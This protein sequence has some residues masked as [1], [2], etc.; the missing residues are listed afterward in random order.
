M[1]KLIFI[2]SLLAFLAVNASAAESIPLP[3]T[4]DNSIVLVDGEWNQNAGQQG[5]IRI[6]GNQHIV[7]MAFDTSSISGKR[8]T[9]ATLVCA[10]G[11]QT[12]S[13][14]TL[15]TIAAPWDENRSTGLTAGVD[16]VEGWGYAG[17]R[18]PA[19]CGGNSFTLA[20]E[21]NS[22]IHD[23]YYHWDVPPDMVHAMAI[24]VAH[25]LAIHEHD[26]DYG[27]NPAIFSRE[28]SGKK[29]RLIVEFDDQ[30]D[31][32]PGPP[33][34]LQLSHSD[35]TSARLLLTA[36][37]SGF[38]YEVL[39][40]GRPLGRHNI[41]L[42]SG[43]SS[44]II[45]L[46]DLPAFI[47]G[48]EPHEIRVVTLNRTG[49]RSEAAVIRGSVFKSSPLDKP[50]VVI[51]PPHRSP[52]DNLSVI[53]IT[54]KY[55]A[56]GQ[57]VGELP[58][59]YRTH[60]VLFDGQ[61]VRLVAAAGEVTGFQLL[62]R[63][64]R[65]VTVKVVLD[66]DGRGSKT[67]IDLLQAVYVPS[68]GRMIPDPLLPL[69]DRIQLSP[70]RDQ[71]VVADLFLPFDASPGLR[72][73]TIT[74]SDGRVIPLEIEV[75]PFALPRQATFFCEMN[76]YGLP[77]HVNDYYAHQ[78]VAYD[79][80]VHAN[81]L[82]YSHNTAAP[83][84]RKS[85]LDMRLR[86][87]RRMDNQRY[88][89]IPPEATAAF[90]DDF[91]EAFG[92][93]IDGS[94]FKDGHRGPVPAPGFYLTFHES[95]P[96]NCRAFFNGNPDAFQAFSEKPEYARTYVNI[97]QDF[98]RLAKSKGWT[99]TG[100]QVYFNNKGSLGESSKAPW[101][102][103]EP[104]SFW[105]YRALKFYGELT[106]R[107]RSV[108]PEVHI[109]YRIDISRPEFCRGQLDQRDDLWIVS[110]WAFQHYRRL[111][112]D[113]ME[114]DGLKA[115]VYGTSNHVHETNRNIQ[116]WALDVW[117]DGATGIVPW[118]TVNKSGSALREA[119]QLGL[120]IFDKDP[121]GETV[122]RHSIRLKAYREAQQLIEYLNLLQQRKGWSRDQ[123]RR[124]VNQYV[125][126][127]GQVSKTSEEDAGTTSYGRL[128]AVNL[129]TLRLAAAQLLK[130]NAG[131]ANR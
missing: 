67:R 111:V 88:D 60:N 29:P 15:S 39:I 99:G 87:G 19:V 20:H 124:F 31:P 86:S 117:Q 21:V 112:T 35:S 94:L 91:A 11:E 22:K 10:Q 80:R 95:W 108:S 103:D 40:D 66:N 47:S 45:P 17:S 14:V 93:Y 72:K 77:D 42:V 57:P 41:P 51:S 25:G 127:N 74:I 52:I 26:A 118:Q 9:K 56:A 4:K 122:I 1:S 49:Q 73:G 120:F 75:L 119:D 36:P 106:D 46:R 38:A 44:Q 62:L 27:R 115:W 125:N 18:F 98:A 33:V 102:L 89:N 61:R 24:G 79:H 59:D 85:N 100:F 63:G 30:V 104:S 123:M 109:D 101:I 34:D 131:T 71:A 121:S 116:A 68:N 48:D 28:Q 53:P 13:A 90:W 55:D 83:G 70:D 128:S 23:G 81:I 105:D 78:Q 65:E 113:R 58:D 114:R 3:V 5:R 129:E 107:G 69:P 7:V 96:L 64:R 2:L 8:V 6:K 126:L 110:S 43:D 54:D 32:I 97:L 82:H 84:S 37:K 76:G 50:Q 16:G 92:P 12:I 130:A